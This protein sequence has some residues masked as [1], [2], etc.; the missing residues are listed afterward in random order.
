MLVVELVG[1]Y[2]LLIINNIA[3]MTYHKIMINNLYNHS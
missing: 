3:I 2:Q 1:H